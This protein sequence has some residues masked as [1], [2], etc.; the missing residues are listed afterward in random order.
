MGL[1]EVL[2]SLLVLGIG[3]L[4]LALLLLSAMRDARSASHRTRA[5]VL[6]A[7]L[8]DRIRANPSARDAYALA[9]DSAA[10]EP[11]GCAARA[12]QP[13]STCSAE[14]LAQDDLADWLARL[15][16][17]LPGGPDGAG[18]EIAFSQRDTPRVD[19]YE[20]RKKS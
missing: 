3:V 13:A 4:G 17:E 10:P 8:A 5:L 15:R 11:H 9:A 19:R 14:E 1:V 18:A 2:L 7:D 20:L 16:D 6:E 12:G